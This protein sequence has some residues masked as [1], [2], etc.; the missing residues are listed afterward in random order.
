MVHLHIVTYIYLKVF[1]TPVKCLTFGLLLVQ[2]AEF[3]L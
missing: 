2:S 3:G 1:C